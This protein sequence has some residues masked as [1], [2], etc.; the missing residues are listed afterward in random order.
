MHSAPT[1]DSHAVLD[2]AEANVVALRRVE[3]ERLR[4]AR[5][6]AEARPPDPEQLARMPL[7]ARS[8]GACGL[9]VEQYAEAELAGAL[10]IS[11]VAALRLMG[12]AVDLDR[13]MPQTWRA[14]AEGRLPVWV[15][16]K[17]A[18]LTH[19]LDAKATAWVDAQLTDL[20][21]SLSPGRLLR[22]VEGRVVQADPELAE[23]KAAAAART[24]GVWF[25]R[26]MADG[27]RHL[28][29]RG[30]VAGIARFEG[31]IGHL[32]HLL[33]E[34]CPAEVGLSHEEL[35][36]EALVLLANP[37]AALKL[38]VGAA[39]EAGVDVAPE[40]VAEA[41]R[42]TD[43]KKYRP[44]TTLYLHCTP[45]LL[46]GK[47]GVVR[48]EELGALTRGQLID[49]LGHEHITLKPVIDLNTEIAADCYETPSQV[50]EQVHLARPADCFPYAE[51]L[52]RKADH[53]HT[54]PYQWRGP[55]GQ[56][57]LGNLGLLTRRNHNTKTHAGWRVWQHEGRFT[58]VSPHG[59]IYLTDAHG[60]HTVSM[61]AGTFDLDVVL[62]DYTRAA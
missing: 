1:V 43:A 27:S 19:D 40:V 50:S 36:C 54:K 48:A 39:D 57:R 24:R 58:W 38:L 26:E 11:S 14:V 47:G 46:E 55:P 61:E 8:L 29:A 5:D 60:T 42:T 59:R 44:R 35:L 10:Q 45:E 41:I 12:D 53:D 30:E 31:M 51:S 33:R 18:D 52:S 13:R 16:R 2:A 15:A 17:I 4:I 49:L 9:L 3:F 56:T 37:M 6:W 28:F 62:T 7:C 20:L 22:V 34:H 21:G 25:G 23:R 32:A